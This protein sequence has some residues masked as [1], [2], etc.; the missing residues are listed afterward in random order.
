MTIASKGDAVEFGKLSQNM[1]AG[2]AC[3]NSVRGIF[4]GGYAPGSSNNIK[5]I[6]YI[7]HMEL[8][9]EIWVL[10]EKSF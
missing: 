3:S 4:A 10:L 9:L 8:I 2:D 5:T 7:I 6:Q 1:Q